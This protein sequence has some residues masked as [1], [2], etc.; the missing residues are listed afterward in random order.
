MIISIYNLPFFSNY[1]Q[2]KKLENDEITLTLYRQYKLYMY[3]K[4]LFD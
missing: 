3:E 4:P 2:Y 1:N